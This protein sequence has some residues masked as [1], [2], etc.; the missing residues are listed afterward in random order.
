[1]TD[2]VEI[3]RAHAG[4]YRGLHHAQRCGNRTAGAPNTDGIFR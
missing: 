3:G 1:M 2:R 4:L